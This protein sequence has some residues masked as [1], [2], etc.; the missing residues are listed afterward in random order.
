MNED[1]AKISDLETLFGN[2]VGA[3][4]GFAGITLFVMLIVGGFRYITAG[5]DPKGV[6]TAKKTIGN[7]IAG[8]VLVTLSFLTLQ[9]IQNFTGVNVTEFKIVD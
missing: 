6:E 4:L 9:L 2:I 1:V 3:A 8:L 5:G 7:A